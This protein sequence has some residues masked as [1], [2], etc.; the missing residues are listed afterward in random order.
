MTID[1]RNKVDYENEKPDIK[2]DRLNFILLLLLYVSQSAILG[3]SHA[4]SFVLQRRKASYRDQ[5][6]LRILVCTIFEIFFSR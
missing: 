2:G 3:M 6:R 4:F 5:V 1:S